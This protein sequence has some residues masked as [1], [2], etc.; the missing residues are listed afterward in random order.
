[1]PNWS[2]AGETVAPAKSNSLEASVLDLVQEE[3][4]ALQR[5]LAFNDRGKLQEYLEGL[6]S[7]ECRIQ[8]SERDRHSHHQDAFHEDPLLHVDMR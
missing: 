4:K 6:R 3:T 2:R 1:M 8:L 5:K 7:I